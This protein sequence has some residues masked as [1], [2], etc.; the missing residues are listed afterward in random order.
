M[1]P[2]ITGDTTNPYDVIFAPLGTTAN[3]GTVVFSYGGKTK[4]VTIP[5]LGDP[6]IN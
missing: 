5:K 1:T 6:T 3:Y 2:T 4:T